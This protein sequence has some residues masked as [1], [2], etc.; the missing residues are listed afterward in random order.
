MISLHIETGRNLIFEKVTRAT[1]LAKK[2]PRVDRLSSAKAV[3][4]LVLSGKLVRSVGDLKCHG[5][6]K[7]GDRCFLWRNEGV[8]EV[9]FT[10]LHRP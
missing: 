8:G 2:V 10:A 9:K 7:S 3:A 1:G 4:V 6:P 5:G